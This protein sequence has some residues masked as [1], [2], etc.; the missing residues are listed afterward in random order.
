MHSLS[1]L[2]IVAAA[3]SILSGCEH[4]LAPPLQT[5]PA[6]T[7]AEAEAMRPHLRSL[8]DAMSAHGAPRWSR[9]AAETLL[10]YANGS[11]PRVHGS[12]GGE[13]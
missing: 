12:A 2:A 6:P 8:I 9:D 5:V 13:P 11:S 3:L 1:R 7:P 4:V 10:G